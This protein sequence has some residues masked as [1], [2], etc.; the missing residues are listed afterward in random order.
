[1]LYEVSN[2]KCMVSSIVELLV[3]SGAVGVLF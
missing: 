2:R 1:M 3:S